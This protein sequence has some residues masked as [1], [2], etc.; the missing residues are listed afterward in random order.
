MDLNNEV[1]SQLQNDHLNLEE[2]FE[3]S[4]EVGA[5]RNLFGPISPQTML[6]HIDGGITD[7]RHLLGKKRL[8]VL[9]DWA[10]RTEQAQ[11][12]EVRHVLQVDRAEPRA[13]PR[14]SS[15][16]TP[17]SAGRGCRAH[18]HDSEQPRAPFAPA[19]CSS[20]LTTGPHARTR[21]RPSTRARRQIPG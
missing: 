13:S 11:A 4:S 8:L 12:I 20:R 6:V 18:T 9:W 17:S 3:Q 21:G 7:G 1:H 15:A 16:R 10:T 19:A 5:S 2:D 14:T